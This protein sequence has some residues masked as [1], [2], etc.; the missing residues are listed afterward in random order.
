MEFG[1][2][3]GAD[4]ELPEE[5]AQ[6]ESSAAGE[7]LKPLEV[8]V[9]G[10]VEPPPLLV[11]PPLLPPELVDPPVEDDPPPVELDPVLPPGT[12]LPLVVPPPPTI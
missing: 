4:E 11:P 6:S 10:A 2:T 12:V 3:P 5:P 8:G 1:V 9:V 7:K